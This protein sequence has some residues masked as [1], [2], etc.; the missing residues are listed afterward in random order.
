MD[1][2]VSLQNN[3][4]YTT[5]SKSPVSYPA[6]FIY[7]VFGVFFVGIGVIGTIVPLI[8]TTPFMVFAAICFGKSSPKL[9]TWFV[10]TGFYK[11][12]INR[13]IQSRS[14]TIKAKLILLGSITLFMGLSFLT[15]VFLSAPLFAMVILIVIWLCHVVY[16]GFKVKTVK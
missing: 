5:E 15:M 9:H 3:N 16:F 4:G 13:F 6:K 8:P 14:M 2:E 12:S 10:S 7:I 11:K 1:R